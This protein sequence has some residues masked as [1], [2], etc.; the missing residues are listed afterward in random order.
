[1]N[2]YRVDLVNE[3][4]VPCGMNSIRYL[5]DSLKQ[6]RKALALASAPVGVD[7]WDKPDPAY[8][9]V[10]SHWDSSKQQYVILQRAHGR[11]A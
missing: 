3:D 6:A 5:G 4:R 10:L 1:M 8:Y 9:P 2:N 11:A 7:T